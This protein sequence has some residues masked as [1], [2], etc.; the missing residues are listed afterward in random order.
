[1]SEDLIEQTLRK[2]QDCLSETPTIIIGSGASVDYDIPSMQDLGTEAITFAKNSGYLNEDE[3]AEFESQTHNDG[4]E[5]AIDNLDLPEDLRL[6]LLKTIWALI[7]DADSKVLGR[8]TAD[9]NILSLTRLY[10]HLFSSTNRTIDVISLN[11]DRVAEYAAEA[12]GFAHFT[13][14]HY[15][16]LRKQ[17]SGSYL[18]IVE[19]TR[20]LRT[21]RIWKVHGSIDWFKTDDGRVLSIDDKYAR[22]HLT[23]LIVTPGTEKYKSTHQQPFRSIINYSDS[24]IDSA[25]AFLII[26]YGFNDE[27]IQPKLLDSIQQRNTPIVVLVKQLT[28]AGRRLLLQRPIHNYVILEAEGNGTRIHSSDFHG[29]D[30]VVPDSNFWNLDSFLT[31]AIS[32]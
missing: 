1:M 17:T 20:T 25:T 26:G 19:S 21:V 30:V 5:S 29:N 27:H 12:A 4:F 24:A 11:Y 32:R 10:Q 15:G 8:L 2:A 18:R 28:R 31:K 3:I 23:P 16:H 6:G 22:S 9:S 7:E 13:G 14:F